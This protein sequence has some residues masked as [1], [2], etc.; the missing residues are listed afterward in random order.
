MLNELLNF[1]KDKNVIVFYQNLLGR[2][3]TLNFSEK[4]PEKMRGRV[5]EIVSVYIV[6][7]NNSPWCCVRDILNG[8]IMT[9]VP[10]VHLVIREGESVNE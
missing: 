10:I 5:C 1:W 2:K 9:N 3:C 8:Q 4:V 6:E 7:S